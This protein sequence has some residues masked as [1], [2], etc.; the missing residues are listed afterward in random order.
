ME[1]L[2]ESLRLVVDDENVTTSA[3]EDCSGIID[4]NKIVPSN[5]TRNP[6]VRCDFFLEFTSNTPDMYYNYE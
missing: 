2:P 6:P 5:S 1:P 3:Y 4:D